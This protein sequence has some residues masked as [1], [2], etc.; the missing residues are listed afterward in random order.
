MANRIKELRKQKGLTQKELAELIDVAPSQIAFYETGKRS[1]RKQQTWEE[2][3]KVLDTSVAY[4]RGYTV[5]DDNPVLAPLSDDDVFSRDLSALET[6]LSNPQGWDEM[7]KMF[8]VSTIEFFR[9][10]ARAL[11]D[12]HPDVWIREREEQILNKYRILSDENQVKVIEYMSMLQKA[13]LY[14]KVVNDGKD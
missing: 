9:A 10:T 6:Y 13:E 12:V 1:P 14:D 11:P 4:L 3:A 7:A 5:S 8:G 2:L